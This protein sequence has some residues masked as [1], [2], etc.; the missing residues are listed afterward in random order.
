MWSDWQEAND[1][2]CS[3]MFWPEPANDDDDP[4]YDYE[5]EGLAA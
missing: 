4:G 5:G 2:A 3:E 1:R